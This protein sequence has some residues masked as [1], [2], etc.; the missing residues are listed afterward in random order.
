MVGC[1]DVMGPK[2]GE[3][4]SSLGFGRAIRDVKISEIQNRWHHC[5]NF[6]PYDSQNSMKNN[7][8][9]EISKMSNMVEGMMCPH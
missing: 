3:P 6:H 2:Q 9:I 5:F 8:D 1:A 4:S 7:T